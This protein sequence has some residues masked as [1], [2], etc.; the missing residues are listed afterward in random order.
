[1]RKAYPIILKESEGEYYVRIPDFD[2]GTQG[3]DVAD[4]IIMARDAIGLVGI[5]MEDDGKSLPEPNTAKEE[6]EEGDIY[7]LVDVD[8]TEYRRKHEGKSVKK[9][10]TIP[11]WLNE[12]AI[13]AGVNFSRILQ[14]ALINYLNLN[15]TYNG[16]K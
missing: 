2:I 14:D 3:T 5:D 15:N 12:E 13:K 1:M 9:N 10:C 16:I 11:Y 4:A 6:A 8:F 7:T